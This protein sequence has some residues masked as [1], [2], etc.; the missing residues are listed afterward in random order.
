MGGWVGGW[1][2]GGGSGDMRPPSAHQA[3]EDGVGAPQ[4]RRL[5]ALLG[6]PPRPQ[7]LD[8]GC[9]VNGHR[10]GLRGRMRA[11]WGGGIGW[12]AAG[13]LAAA[14][15]VSGGGRAGVGG[16]PRASTRRSGNRPVDRRHALHAPQ[17][18]NLGAEAGDGLRRR[19][20]GGRRRRQLGLGQ[21]G[22]EACLILACQLCGLM[23]G[24]WWGRRMRWQS[25]RARSGVGAAS[26]R[27]SCPHSSKPVCPAR[28]NQQ[29]TASHSGRSK[30]QPAPRPRWRGGRRRCRRPPARARPARQALADHLHYLPS[31]TALHPTRGTRLLCLPQGSGCALHHLRHGMRKMPRR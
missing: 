13:A 14:V 3:R 12:R 26:A 24:G 30:G 31:R 1:W 21:H 25:M 4:R 5:I 15:S 11:G 7:R 19:H 23:C 29:P 16:P 20:V 27:A 2:E 8:L 6:V 28:I 18:P 10:G 22:G 17:R 9:V